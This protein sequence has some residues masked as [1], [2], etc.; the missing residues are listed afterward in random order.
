MTTLEQSIAPAPGWWPLSWSAPVF[1]VL[2]AAVIVGALQ[3]HFMCDDAYINFRYASNAHDGH[4]LV[5]NPPPFRPVEGYTSLSWL[6]LLWAMWS[7]FGL[8]P[9]IAANILSY[10]CGILQLLVV[11]AAAHAIRDRDGRRVGPGF[12]WLTVAAVAGSRTFLQWFSGG[13]ETSLFN[14]TFLTW[15]VLCFGDGPGRRLLLWAGSAALAALTRPDGLLLVA[16]TIA[17]SLASRTEWRLSWRQLA[18]RL[19]PLA[20][21]AAHFAFRR[22][23]YGEWLPNTYYAKVVG[24][25]PEAGWRYLACFAAEHGVWLW[26]VLVF[27]WLAAA[28]RRKGHATARWRASLAPIAAVGTVVAHCAYYVVRVGGD[29]FEYRVISHLVPMM[30]LSAAAMTAHLGWRVLPSAAAVAGLWLAAA[31]G[32][33]HLALTRDMPANGL[34]LLAPRVPAVLQPV[35]RWYDRHQSWLHWHFICLRCVQHARALQELS[36]PLPP[37]TRW[38]PTPDDI[39]VQAAECVGA[40]GWA[41]PDCAIVDSHGLNDWVVARTPVGQHPLFAPERLGSIFESADADHDG[42]LTRTELLASVSGILLG[43]AS[44]AGGETQVDLLLC[45]GASQRTDALTVAEADE[46]VR[47][48]FNRGWMAHERLA[49]AAYLAAFEP[50]VTCANGA[51]I[52]RP[53]EHPLTPERVRAVE[54]AW[55]QWILGGARPEDLPAK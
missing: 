17:T 28:S 34:Y 33:W 49:P 25:W 40:C 15:V 1:A 4:G 7:W 31:A 9:P 30:M 23:F 27:A 14:L 13:L 19:S 5:W 43:D 41:L 38:E 45:V 32:W 26:L 20:A 18:M 52:V 22:A 44:G 3:L 36:A 35:V 47:T 50:N 6:L 29:H 11:V 16:A 8:Q 21:V 54:A 55:R 24:A 37:R 12:A 53:R 42:W 51:A 39:P 48:F 2:L 46:L 10:G